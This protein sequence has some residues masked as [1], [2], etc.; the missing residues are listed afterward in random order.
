MD[1]EAFCRQTVDRVQISLA[2][3]MNPP[4]EVRMMLDTTLSL[5]CIT[6]QMMHVYV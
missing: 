4:L 1:I 2:D 6:G 5:D 3:V